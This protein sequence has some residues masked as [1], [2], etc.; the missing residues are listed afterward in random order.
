MKI[1]IIGCGN[2]LAGDDGVGVHVI[3]QLKNISLPDKVSVMEGGTDPLNL[4]EMLRGAEKVILVDA[5]RGAG[6]PGEVYVLGVEQLD[7]E[8][9]AGVSLH[10]FSLAHVLRLG[11]ALC[12]KEM[13]LEIVV[14]GVEAQETSPFNTGLSPAVEAAVPKAIQA[15][16]EQI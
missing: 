16:K 2:P 8:A 6:E 7:L 9:E 11:Q 13:P 4:L 1:K 15:V 3:R 12:P 5:V 14:V 10:Q